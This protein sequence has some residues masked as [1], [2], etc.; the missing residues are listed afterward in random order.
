MSVV[1]AQLYVP[2][3]EDSSKWEHQGI[4]AF[5]VPLRDRATRAILP[6][7]T[8]RNC[9]MKSGLNG[10]V[11]LNFSFFYM[12]ECEVESQSPFCFTKLTTLG[13]T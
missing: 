8:I 10:M 2:H 13:R 4:H 7:I 3:P 9:G 5:L 11:N 6:G 12:Y 1:W